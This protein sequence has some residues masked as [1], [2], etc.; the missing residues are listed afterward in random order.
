MPFK[1]LKNSCT[2]TAI[3]ANPVTIP[4][5]HKP[6]LRVLKTLLIDCQGVTD[7][8]SSFSATYRSTIGI[9]IVGSHNTSSIR[10]VVKDFWSAGIFSG[11]ESA[12]FIPFLSK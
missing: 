1:E 11:M 7:E 2:I 4:F 3:P 9:S 5:P 8:I 12:R 10:D 6:V